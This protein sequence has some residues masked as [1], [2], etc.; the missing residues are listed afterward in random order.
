MCGEPLVTFPLRALHLHHMVTL[1]PAGVTIG[2][3]VPQACAA[4]GVLLPVAPNA[5]LCWHS[6]LVGCLSSSRS[7]QRRHDRFEDSGGAPP[8]LRPV[9][10]AEGGGGHHDEGLLVDCCRVDCSKTVAVVVAEGEED[11]TI[12][13]QQG[14]GSRSSA[15]RWRALVGRLRR[16]I[17]VAEGEERT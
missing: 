12:E 17:V 9:V 8:Q 5:P 7:T 14:S 2:S 1:S 13:V 15:D 4:E 16:G 10:V 11:N 6:L 3:C